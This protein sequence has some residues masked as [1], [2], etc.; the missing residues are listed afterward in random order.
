VY[1]AEE[2]RALSGAATGL[3]IHIDGARFANA[4]VST[5]AS[6]ADLTWRAGA[7]LLTFGATKSGALAAEAIVVFRKSLAEEL[8]LRH[9]RAGQRIS[10]MR[11]ISAQLDAYLA[12]DLW[13]R[14]ARHA[15]A[16]AQRLAEGLK[17]IHRVEAN[18]VF[19]RFPPAQAAAL[20]EHG[21]RFGDWPIFGDDAYR[22][23]TAFDTREEEVDGFLKSAQC[24]VHGAQESAG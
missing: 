22:L 13:L 14:N 16:M 10:K 21:F 9:H 24:T 4:V 12:D 18:V 15:N 6:P 19:A 8:A 17:T 23:V 20:R 1:S 2:L 11:F 3:G 7:D 5:G